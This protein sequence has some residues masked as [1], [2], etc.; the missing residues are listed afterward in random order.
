MAPR[1]SRTASRPPAAAG[2][3][4]PAAGL[5]LAEVGF[6]L[7]LF[8]DQGHEVHLT[9]ILHVKSNEGEEWN[10]W[11][12]ARV[13]AFIR[14]RAQLSPGAVPGGPAPAPAHPPRER[15]SPRPPDPA[16]A[17]PPGLELVGLG[18]GALL[19]QGQGLELGLLPGGADPAA[20]RPCR[21]TVHAESVR[22]GTRVYLA[23]GAATLGPWPDA[24]RLRLPGL[25]LPVG[26]HRLLVRLT[27][28]EPDQELEL[29]S[30]VLLVVPA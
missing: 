25:Q 12:G 27:L 23:S 30:R 19:A 13:L 24:L 3:P 14:E 16:P 15:P 26:P 21:Y 4:R 8:V 6:V 7:D 11:D 22:E 29:R 18:P 20:T 2:R 5:E 10:G 28:R 17:S 1:R 9:Q